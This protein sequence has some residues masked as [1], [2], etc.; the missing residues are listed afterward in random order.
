MQIL[1]HLLNIRLAAHLPLCGWFV[2]EYW[3]RKLFQNE[4]QMFLIDLTEEKVSALFLSPT[5]TVLDK[6]KISRLRVANCLI[7]LHGPD[8]SVP[9]NKI[10]AVIA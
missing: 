8:L 7:T 2:R 6:R 1:Y 5:R 3:N 9:L 4:P 10:L